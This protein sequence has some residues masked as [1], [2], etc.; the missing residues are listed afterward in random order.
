MPFSSNCGTPNQLLERIFQRNLE[1]TR[2]SEIGT[3]LGKSSAEHI[4]DTGT[5]IYRPNLRIHP[6]EKGH[7]EKS[8][9]IG[10]GIELSLNR[11]PYGIQSREVDQVPS[12]DQE[13]ACG[14]APTSRITILGWRCG[15]RAARASLGN[16]ASRT[17]GLRKP[18]G[19]LSHIAPL[20]SERHQSPA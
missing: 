9:E 7:N 4:P 19:R 13:R 2:Y 15:G 17:R 18:R 20:G 16:C 10:S 8:I 11:A 5:G 6:A 1:T 14:D 3:R 12:L